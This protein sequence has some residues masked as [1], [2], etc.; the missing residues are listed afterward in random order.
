[1][2]KGNTP[3]LNNGRQ[4]IWVF[5][6]GA[7]V[8][9]FLAFGGTG[10]KGE[11]I[12]SV[13]PA[14]EK[15]WV[16]IAKPNAKPDVYVVEIAKTQEQQEYG[17]MFVK[18]MPDKQGMVFVYETPQMASFWMKNTLIPLDMIFID[19]DS[20]IHHIVTHARPGDT[21]PISGGQKRSMAVLELNAGQAAARGFAVGDRVFFSENTL[22]QTR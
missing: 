11:S 13:R 10:D 8:A 12:P 16:S 21:R 3:Q 5:L 22:T 18:S 7:V 4:Y 14:F 15:G 6:L 2:Y 1:M 9:I 17:L 19:S 20:R